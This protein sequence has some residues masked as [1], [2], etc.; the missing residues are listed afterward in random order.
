MKSSELTEPVDAPNIARYRLVD[1]YSSCTDQMTKET[2]MNLFTKPS[3]LRIIIA[4]I[5]FGMGVDCPDVHHIIHL[6]PSD[7]LESYIQEIGRAGRN[8]A[9][10][11]ATLLV[12][13]K[14]KRYVDDSMRSYIENTE[15][16]RRKV[17]FSEMEGYVSVT[18]E[19]LCLC[20]DL[21]K[22]SCVCNDCS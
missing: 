2:I 21:C 10:S 15:K 5:A 12:T 20:C 11:Y 9:I 6:G 16:C 17:L 8:G 14:W 3:Q 1:M 4:T 19:R 7:D 13:S 22:N 18:L